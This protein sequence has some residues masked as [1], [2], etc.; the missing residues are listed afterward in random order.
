[1]GL[2]YRLDVAVSRADSEALSAIVTGVR[3]LWSCPHVRF[4]IEED[5]LCVT[6]AGHIHLYQSCEEVA[7]RVVRVVEAANQRP[8]RIVVELTQ[9]VDREGRE[10]SEL[11]PY[12]YEYDGR[13]GAQDPD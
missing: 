1:M 6:L 7:R 9:M 11:P 4:H 10:A 12:Q 8:C 2:H 13:P 3:A 5:G